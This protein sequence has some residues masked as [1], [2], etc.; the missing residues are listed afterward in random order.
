[1]SEMDCASTLDILDC[2]RPDAVDLDQPELTQARAHLD[3]CQACQLEFAT[4][5]EFDR[6]VAAVAR[7]VEVPHGLQE[8]LIHALAAQPVDGL[9]QTDSTV[10]PATPIVDPAAARRRGRLRTRLSLLALSCLAGMAVLISSWPQEVE[11]FSVESLLVQVTADPD[12]VQQ[13]ERFDGLPAPELPGSF[14]HGR[15]GTDSSVYGKDLDGDSRHDISMT[16]FKFDPPGYSP[17]M[18]VVA[19]VPASRV[20]ALPAARSFSRAAHQYPSPGGFA[21]ASVVWVEGDTVYLAFIPRRYAPALEVMQ[22]ELQG[23]AV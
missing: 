8:S 10:S 15:L 5:Q 4:R 21:A 17:I 20:T 9:D 23:V 14:H 7:D 13:L 6:A 3:S 12:D 2:V 1:M 19:A 11:R 22:R 18:G 16:V